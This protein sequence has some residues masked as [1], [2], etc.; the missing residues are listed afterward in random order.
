MTRRVLAVLLAAALSAC[1]LPWAPAGPP[2]ATAPATKRPQAMVAAANP[3]AARAGLAVLERGG[4]AV[5][6]AVA[7]QAVLGLV[8]P[9]SSGLGG[10]AFMLHYDAGARQVTAYDGRETAPAGAT[11]D[12]FLGPD[13][14]PLSFRE[15]VVSGR[16]TGAPGAVAMLA[17]AHA[18]HGRL[19]WAG[20]FEDGVALA[21]DG[22]VVSP[23]LS[24]F[25]NRA[26]A[27][28]EQPDFTAYFTEADGTLV[29]AGDRLRNPAYAESLRRIA[30]D[31]RAL[32]EGPLADAVAARTHAAPLPGSLTARDIRAYR[33]RA[34][35]ALC[36]PWRVYRLC[37]AQPPSSGAVLLQ[38][39]L[40]LEANPAVDGGA[41]SPA[42][43][44][45]LVQASRLMYADRDRWLGD[46]AFVRVPT[47]GLLDPAYVAARAG[48]I[49]ERLGA[50][51]S[52][53]TPPGA[54]AVAADRTR[55]PAGTSHF[56]I[57]DRWGNVVSMTT[58]VESVF[59][60]GRM[61][62]G[63]FLNN[64]LTD[65]SFSPVGPDGIAAANA[66][67][68]GKRPRSSMSPVIVLDR[69][70][71]FV[72]AV[73]SPGGSAI[74]AY[75]LKALLGMLAWNLTPQ[76]AIDLPN[77]IARGAAIVGEEA[78][79]DPA[80]RAGLAERGIVVASGGGEESG[81]HAVMRRDGR[82]LGGADPRREGV[83]LED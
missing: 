27:Q 9:Q 5:D 39:M 50:P 61:V 20:L 35:G 14:K 80:L 69:E 51:P 13:G 19:P 18:D 45:A 6:A 7:V 33:P 47:E 28:A 59:G 56:V 40:M 4:S 25:V 31:P 32:Y 74:L 71:R 17:Q 82:L 57:V 41:Q 21:R 63:F 15:A 46:P 66:V 53:G 34:G 73:G 68:P 36:R 65:F 60:T 42:A 48:L 81:L 30:A 49:G 12:M 38:A 29:E 75:N 76:Q 70:G 44:S 22:F 37:T 64:Q 78:K 67:A 83:V 26:S 10:G 43:W 58:T 62:G 16:A 55:E 11:P 8:E 3:L 77:V 52:A 79:L 1:A 54:P 72:A 23:R 24:R 2:T